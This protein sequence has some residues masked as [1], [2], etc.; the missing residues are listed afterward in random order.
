M[1]LFFLLFILSIWYVYCL[2]TT[3]LEQKFNAF[4]MQKNQDADTHE[5]DCD[6]NEG[7]VIRAKDPSIR[8]IRLNPPRSPHEPVPDVRYVCK[9]APVMRGPVV[10]KQTPT[11]S[12][13]RERE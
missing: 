3:V 11:T 1:E 12:K 9:K 13:E 2:D 7:D 8:G 6:Y 10:C 5:D 4:S